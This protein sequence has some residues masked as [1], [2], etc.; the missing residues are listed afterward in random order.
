MIS[1]NWL[2]SLWRT[3]YKGAA[4]YVETDTEGGARR[5]VI[6]EFPMRDYPYLE[7]LGERHRAFTVTA[8]VSSDRA[9]AEATVLMQVCAMRGP[10]I[11]V[12]P[13]QGP[14]LVRCL[15]F[16][17]VHQKDKLGYIAHDLQFVREGFTSALASATNLINMIFVQAEQ[18]AAVAAS[19]F[20]AVAL[21]KSVPDYVSHALQYGTEEALATLDVVR[22]A[23]SIDTDVNAAQRDA[24][25]A[26]YVALPIALTNEDQEALQSIGHSV[27][28]VAMALAENTDPSIALQSMAEILATTPSEVTQDRPS[29]SIWRAHVRTNR[30]ASYVLLRTAALIA[31]CE[32]IAKAELKDRPAAITLRA[33]VSN[34]F[35]D[36]LGSLPSEQYELFQIMTKLRDATIEY[37]SRAILDLAPVVTVSASLSMPSLYWSWRLFGDPSR[38][39]ELVSRNRVPHPSFMPPKFEAL[40]K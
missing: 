33:N 35:E 12:L 23:S 34:Y 26:A 6:H 39:D 28:K 27:V 5:I 30:N 37:L 15:E 16:T 2:Q 24:I 10:G 7:D 14:V 13:T 40:G 8:Y 18:A 38:T 9:D 1:R 11:L 21:I 20:A 17:R 4:F 31:Y 22:T 32:A 29:T 36:Q 19:V 25:Q 3:S